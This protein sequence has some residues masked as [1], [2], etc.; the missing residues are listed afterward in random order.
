MT[1]A[2]ALLVALGAFPAGAS[3]C[4]NTTFLV[5]LEQSGDVALDSKGN[6]WFTSNID[7]SSVWS[8]PTDQSHQCQ[9]IG[10]QVWRQP[11]GIAVDN[12][13]DQPTIYIAEYS[14]AHGNPAVK[15]CKW[16]DDGTLACIDFGDGW[17]VPLDVV[18][19]RSGSI[20]IAD[21]QGKDCNVW[22]FS[23][24]G[25]GTFDRTLVTS[26]WGLDSLAVDSQGTV[27]V[28]SFYQDRW[29]VSRCASTGNCSDFYYGSRVSAGSLLKAVA[30]GPDDSVYLSLVESCPPDHECPPYDHIIRCPPEHEWDEHHPDD[31][32]DD[33]GAFDG[34][35]KMVVDE[36]G[37]I[38]TAGGGL[39]RICLSPS[40][41]E[42]QV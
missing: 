13:G 31:D 32:C 34:V 2:R 21:R 6:A 28:T 29:S 36:N 10:D 15:S 24:S 38:Y 5:A 16:N 35:G 42:I 22:K 23:R 20:F 33:L 27:Y 41:Q 40:M 3:E 4:S 18:V 19:D 14:D 39:R 25:D 11:Q 17:S 26:T 1:T 8:C 9:E 37:G 12:L 7:N 30:V